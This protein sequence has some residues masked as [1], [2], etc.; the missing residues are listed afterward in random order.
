MPEWVDAAAVGGSFSDLLPLESICGVDVTQCVRNKHQGQPGQSM[1]DIELDPTNPFSMNTN[2]ISPTNDTQ[3]LE[4][5]NP[6]NI[7]SKSTNPLGDDCTSAEGFP[8]ITNANLGESTNPFEDEDSMDDYLLNMENKPVITPPKLL[9]NEGAVTFAGNEK[10]SS[11]PFE[12]GEDMEH[13]QNEDDPTDQSETYEESFDNGAVENKDDKFG[14]DF[15]VTQMRKRKS[16]IR[17]IGS[18][19]RTPSVKA[20]QCPKEFCGF[21]T[22]T[23]DKLA[24]HVDRVH[25]AYHDLL[26]P[27]S[28]ELAPKT[29]KSSIYEAKRLSDIMWGTM[30]AGKIFITLL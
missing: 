29:Q 11:N 5:T 1:G 9:V 15:T 14:K 8:C 28:P 13:K 22:S 6:L 4:P 25:G 26:S 27:H 2:A 3:E 10:S 17:R 18:L 20:F 24:V 21:L 12:D 30:A 16:T 19:K 7:E 23:A